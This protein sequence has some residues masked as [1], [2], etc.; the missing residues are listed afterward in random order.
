MTQRKTKA[1]L[2]AEFDAVVQRALERIDRAA[3]HKLFWPK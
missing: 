3:R 2:D 1:E